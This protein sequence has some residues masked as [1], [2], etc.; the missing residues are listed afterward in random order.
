MGHTADLDQ[1]RVIQ[2]LDKLASPGFIVG[3]DIK[4]VAEEDSGLVMPDGSKAQ[5]NGLK[6]MILHA[7]IRS[8]IEHD[9]SI[10]VK[11]PVWCDK[12][13]AQL[14]KLNLAHR[15]RVHYMFDMRDE[16]GSEA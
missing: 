16:P 4:F 6:L 2:A 8:D 3:Y 15:P 9:D 11:A 5:S 7:I 10:F 14:N 1:A 12:L 13:E